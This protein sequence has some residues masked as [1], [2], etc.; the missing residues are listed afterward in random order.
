MDIHG[1][2]ILLVLFFSIKIMIFKNESKNKRS[3]ILFLTYLA[4]HLQVTSVRCLFHQ[5]IIILL[6]ISPSVSCSTANYVIFHNGVP[7]MYC[8]CHLLLIVAVCN[9]LSTYCILYSTKQFAVLEHCLYWK[10]YM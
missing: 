8:D 7:D 4:L 5:Y 2:R 3:V 1:S 6:T 10:Y 9:T